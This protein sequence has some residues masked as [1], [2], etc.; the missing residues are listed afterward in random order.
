MI[1]KTWKEIFDGLCPDAEAELRIWDNL[2]RSAGSDVAEKQIVCVKTRSRKLW[3]TVLLAAALTGAMGATAFA[4]G[5]F[6][7]EALVVAEPEIT[8]H[9]LVV[10]EDHKGH[11]VDNPEEGAIFSITQPQEVPEDLDPAIR[12]KI[13]NNKA[14]WEEW[15]TWLDENEL[16]IP[17]V[18]DSPEGAMRSR[19][20]ENGDGSWT[21]VFSRP[22]KTQEELIAWVN[23]IEK[24]TQEDQERGIRL[25][26]EYEAYLE[27]SDNWMELERRS[28][29]AR[30]KEQYDLALD[31]ENTSVDGF[32]HVYRVHT[33]EQGDKLQE[34]CHRYGLV[35][36][37]DQN[38]L[39]GTLE[40]YYSVH[41]RPDWMSDADYE[42][43]VR[44][45]TTGLKA[46]EQLAQLSENCCR[47]DLFWIA[48]PFV[49]HLYWYQEGSFAVNY[50]WLTAGG[51]LAEC[52][53]YNSMYDTLSSGMELFQE[54]ED[55]SAYSSR[56][57][58]TK[59]GTELTILESDHENAW[60]HRDKSFLY[61]YLQ[62]SFLVLQVD[63]AK[64]LTAEE[65]NAIADSIHY[66]VVNK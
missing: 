39:F 1:E 31:L 13:E 48:P 42:R 10:G 55:V 12:Q 52:Y 56:A 7:R 8:P 57:Y 40:D 26:R 6:G 65:L 4:S 19:L 50:T 37:G 64:G 24:V 54:I 47:G 11:L 27:D 62:D 36:R 34:I 29:S 30:E 35:L 58:I 66:S 51:E 16:R 45:D 25:Y 32:D 61:V 53:L 2:M 15:E 5:L 14:A 18:F 41:G 59:D 22:K 60:G 20:K 28:V 44:D 46:E 17:A 33:R 43:L 3:R 63:A 23:E 9:K 49:D 38:T 21:L